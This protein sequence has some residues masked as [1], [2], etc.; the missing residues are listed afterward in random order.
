MK[1]D[2]SLR[3]AMKARLDA[4]PKCVHKKW[5]D[6]PTGAKALLTDLW[7][8]FQLAVLAFLYAF[9]AW[10]CTPF[11]YASLAA[12]LVC[13]VHV[14][15]CER[16]GQCKASWLFL[17]LISGGCGYIVYILAD[18]HVCYG[19]DRRRFAEISK[20]ARPLVGDFEIGDCAPAVLNDCRYLYNAGGFAAYSGTDI[21]YFS[22]ARAMFE[23]ALKTIEN[24]Q[25]FIFLEFFI[26]SEGT[27]LERLLTILSRKVEQGVEVR[28][29]YDDAGCQGIFT[30]ATKKRIRESGINMRVFA[31]MFAPFSFGLNF[32]DHRKIIVVD[33]KTGYAGG[34]NIADECVNEVKM[35]GYWKDSGVR[36]DGAAVDGLCLAFM[37]QWDFATREKTGYASYLNHYEKTQN[38]SLVVPFAGGPEIEECLCRGV[39][40]NLIAGAQEKLYF[41][42]PYFVPDGDIL[43]AL[44]QKALSGVDVRIVLPTVP[45]YG[46]I[47]KVSR[48]NA[49]RLIACGVKVYFVRGAFV[50][51][52][53][54]LTENAVTVGSVNMD[55]RAFYQEFDNGVY[56]NDKGCMEAVAADFE[57]IFVGNECAAKSKQNIFSRFI[58]ACLRVVSPLM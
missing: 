26:F 30:A 47:Y 48:S 7:L 58:T 49:E 11:F 1:M 12:T 16:D 14:L 28:I 44:K 20:R 2:F 57:E 40:A 6:F 45:D 38:D 36:L 19:Y 50:H 35:N 37:R 23:D 24:A 4:K 29:L 54:M 3:E 21:E 18:K 52:K 17:L 51:T 13:A 15:V 10:I 32:R 9:F 8:A 46:F 53:T 43:N 42:T 33:G 34:C 56:T 22:N 55:M 25:K 5:V 39:Y 31:R 27:L 41:M